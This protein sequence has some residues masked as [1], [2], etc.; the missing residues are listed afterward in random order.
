QA[1][2]RQYGP[3][4]RPQERR[5]SDAACVRADDDQLHREDGVGHVGPVPAAGRAGGLRR[6]AIMSGM[7]DAPDSEPRQPPRQPL[8]GVTA[9]IVPRPGLWIALAVLLAAGI[10]A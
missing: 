7:T 1:C 2:A 6:F 9:S 4:R 5:G 3:G 8:A 10:L